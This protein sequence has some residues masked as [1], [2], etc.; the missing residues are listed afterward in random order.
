MTLRTAQE[1]THKSP[2][3]SA[4]SKASREAMV[5]GAGSVALSLVGS[6]EVCS[7]HQAS[8]RLAAVAR[9]WLHWVWFLAEGLSKRIFQ[10]L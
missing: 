1:N 6:P 4:F 3:T 2:S 8:I 9:V 5:L 7:K 10:G